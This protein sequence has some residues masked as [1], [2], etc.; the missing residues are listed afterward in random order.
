M[1]S[2]HCVFPGKS[3]GKQ[4][5]GRQRNAG[6]ICPE[7]GGVAVSYLSLVKNFSNRFLA[8]QFITPLWPRCGL[9]ANEALGR[10]ERGFLTTQVPISDAALRPG[11]RITNAAIGVSSIF[12]EPQREFVW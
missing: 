3:L 9:L 11:E 10:F 1:P 5:T 8:I 4:L 7:T 12:F 6:V 2:H